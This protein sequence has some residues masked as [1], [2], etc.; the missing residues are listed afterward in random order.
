MHCGGEL[1]ML[2]T[3]ET[4]PTHFFVRHTVTVA[5]G[6]YAIINIKLRCLKLIFLQIFE[7]VEDKQISD[8]FRRDPFLVR[9]VSWE[10]FSFAM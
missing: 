6:R 4:P 3:A 10:A 7:A 1:R 5:S 8:R 9:P 2:L